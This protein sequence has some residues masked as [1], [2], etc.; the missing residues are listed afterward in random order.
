MNTECHIKLRDK[1]SRRVVEY[2]GNRQGHVRASGHFKVYINPCL[3]SLNRS[4][5]GFWL[6][7]LS[8]TALCIADDAYLMSNTPSGLQSAINIICHYAKRYQLQFNAT[9][10][11]IVVT[12]SK[13]DMTLLP[14]DCSMDSQWGEDRSGR[15]E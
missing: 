2:K 11:K 13:I 5:L 12:G 9:K 4:N 8:I 3:L 15:Y 6:G 10:T 7:P 1:L 14:R